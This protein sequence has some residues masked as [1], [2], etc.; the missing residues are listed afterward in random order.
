MREGAILPEGYCYATR[1]IGQPVS[2]DVDKTAN[3]VE[4]VDLSTPPKAGRHVLEG[5]AYTPKSAACA[6]RNAKRNTNRHA[7]TSFARKMK[8]SLVE[9]RSPTLNVSEDET[10]LKARWHAAAKE[11]A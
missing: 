3:Q 4:T 7:H 2:G 6:R 10:H 11:I 9:R 8:D 1:A 5:V